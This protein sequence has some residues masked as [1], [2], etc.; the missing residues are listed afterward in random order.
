MF[1][2][3]FYCGTLSLSGSSW[4]WTSTMALFIC[5]YK[6][7]PLSN[8]RQCWRQTGQ[9]H[10]FIDT[11]THT[12]THTFTFFP[13][14]FVCWCLVFGVLFLRNRSSVSFLTLF[15]KLNFV[16]TS[17]K[18][19]KFKH[20]TRRTFRSWLWFTLSYGISLFVLW[21]AFFQIFVWLFVLVVHW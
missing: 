4:L 19:N 18:K 6:Y 13:F 14:C 3:K 7:L 16:C 10:S 20:S 15:I 17:G 8:V 21:N 1:I 2:S 12:F 11:H 5:C 9:K